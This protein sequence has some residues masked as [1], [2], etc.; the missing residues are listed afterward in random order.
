MTQDESATKLAKMV[1]IFYWLR[2][3]NVRSSGRA[4]VNH[5]ATDCVSC[6]RQQKLWQNQAK[7]SQGFDTIHTVTHR[8]HT[9]TIF[10]L[11]IFLF[12]FIFCSCFFLFALDAIGNVSHF[13]M[14]LCHIICNKNKSIRT[15]LWKHN[16]FNADNRI[17]IKACVCVCKCGHCGYYLRQ[18]RRLIIFVRCYFKLSQHA[19]INVWTWILQN[20]QCL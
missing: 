17:A 9:Y 10:L 7:C 20:W 4:I 13:F 2:S 12:V 18:P 8:I 15:F 14:Y 19:T 3:R 6:W 11:L 16:A 1:R 5:I